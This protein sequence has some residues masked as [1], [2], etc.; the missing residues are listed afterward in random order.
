MG[1][2]ESEVVLGKAVNT[3][4]LRCYGVH[5]GQ[6]VVTTA[7]HMIRMKYKPKPSKLPHTL[8]F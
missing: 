2:A 8:L 7:L 5:I 4:V 3:R 6:T 1:L